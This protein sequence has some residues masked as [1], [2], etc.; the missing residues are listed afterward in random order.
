[1]TVV[2]ESQ[3]L[4]RVGVKEV[5]RIDDEEMFDG[6]IHQAI[7]DMS[8]ILNSASIKSEVDGTEASDQAEDVTTHR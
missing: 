8:L 6:T 4:T 7:F 1:M 5:I 2:P 3:N